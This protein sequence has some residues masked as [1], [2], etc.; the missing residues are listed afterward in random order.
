MEW[1]FPISAPSSLP[2][3][4]RRC[5]P[6]GRT[7]GGQ[8]SR[9]VEQFN[10]G[11]SL[12]LPARGFTLIELLV[13]IGIIIALIGLLL[14]TI[15]SVRR[16]AEIT[17]QRRNFQAII[18]ALEAYDQ[19]FRDYPKDSFAMTDIPI[20]SPITYQIAPGVTGAI[21]DAF[22]P[23]PLRTDPTLAMALLGLGPASA[24]G[25]SGGTSYQYGDVDGADGPGFKAKM[26]VVAT[27]TVSSAVA[28][29]QSV[30][31][32]LNNINLASDT[33]NPIPSATS[34]PS[35]TVISLGGPGSLDALVPITSATAATVTTPSSPSPCTITLSRPLA[36]SYNS[37]QPCALLAPAGKTYEPYLPPDNF[38]VQYVQF[39][40]ANQPNPNYETQALPVLLDIWGGPIL[41]FPAY[42]NYTNRLPNTSANPTNTPT[43]NP[44][45][46]VALP[47]GITAPTSVATAGPLFGSPSPIAASFAKNSAVDALGDTVPSVFWSGPLG[48]W[49]PGANRANP[50]GPSGLA[51][52]PN[53]PLTPGQISAILY[54]LGDVN[55]NNTIDNY[56]L[57][58]AS[59]A[60]A[61][62]TEKLAVQ[63]PYFMV[64]PGPDGAF[65]DLYPGQS[66]PPTGSQAY[67]PGIVSKSDDIYDFDQ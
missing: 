24:I 6:G 62:V 60:N 28:G 40:V 25:A 13:A 34:P 21:P 57:V 54:K 63:L 52:D 49:G 42:N 53:V 20:A 7:A 61:A 18:G 46:G 14:P 37:G 30:T 15:G 33:I 2:E 59:G 39:P 56:T 1:T 50:P 22:R 32:L 8:E 47:M 41:Y 51:A 58:T 26:A 36:K 31:V 11:H 3:R 45:G 12:R 9:V 65:L 4:T 5:L 23:M 43:N 67:W 55:S 64:S 17:A 10:S 48:A 19:D 29:T 66:A 35:F 44:A 38:K 27:G 16:K